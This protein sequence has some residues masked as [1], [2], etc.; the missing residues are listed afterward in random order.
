MLSKILLIILCTKY[1]Y[2]FINFY[3]LIKQ[4]QIIKLLKEYKQIK[5]QQIDLNLYCFEIAQV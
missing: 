3:I 2:I 4:K 1:F 5:H